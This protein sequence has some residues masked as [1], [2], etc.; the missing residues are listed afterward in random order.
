[1]YL[2]SRQQVVAEEDAQRASYFEVIVS[3]E[4]PME[5]LRDVLE[6]VILILSSVAA[7][8]GRDECS[9][10]RDTRARNSKKQ[11]GITTLS[12]DKVYRRWEE[13]TALNA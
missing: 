3:G 1:M 2:S 6:D 4:Y 5:L 12:I 11:A 13:E 9:D 10:T 8:R 7:V